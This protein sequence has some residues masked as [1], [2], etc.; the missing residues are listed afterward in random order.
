M[1]ISN[2]QIRSR[3]SE[4]KRRKITLLTLHSW[5]KVL[6]LVFLAILFSQQF[7][8]AYQSEDHYK[9]EVLDQVVFLYYA[10]LDKAAH[11]YETVLGFKQIEQT[12]AVEWVAIYK[13]TDNS[14][15]GIV[16]EKKGTLKTSQ[17]KPVMLSWVTD[18]V[19]AWYEYLKD[20]NVS[21]IRAPKTNLET[22][23][24]AMLLKDT[25][26]YMLEFFQWLE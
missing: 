2:R 13:A 5:L 7:L 20:K 16:D 11:F 12:Q 15:V 3:S 4:Q 14:Y 10:D 18:D 1:N 22:G 24:R 8:I 9:P 23:I 19:D 6:G 25:G 21:I 26:G 17:E